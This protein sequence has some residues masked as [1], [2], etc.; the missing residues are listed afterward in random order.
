MAIS[1]TPIYNGDTPLDLRVHFLKVDRSPSNNNLKKTQRPIF[2]EDGEVNRDIVE[3]IEIEPQSILNLEFEESSLQLGIRGNIRVDNMFNILETIDLN[4]TTQFEIYV[5]IHAKDQELTDNKV[6]NGV[7]VLCYVT[8]LA[9][10]SGGYIN[11]N[12]MFEFEE[13]YVNNLRNI[14]LDR[15]VY[16]YA[17]SIITIID[18]LEFLNNQVYFAAY[19]PKVPFITHTKCSQPNTA[20]STINPGAVKDSKQSMYDVILLM[21]EDTLVGDQYDNNDHSANFKCPYLRMCNDVDG[22]RRMLFAPFVGDEHR[23]LLHVCNDAEQFQKHVDNQYNFSSVY[24]EKF[25]FGP[26]ASITSL[27]PNS[28]PKNAVETYNLSRANFQTL[29]ENVWGNYVIANVGNGSPDVG[30]FFANKKTFL[31]LLRQYAER[32]FSGVPIAYNIPILSPETLKTFE[33]KQGDVGGGIRGEMASRG[34]YN[35]MYNKVAKS[36]LTITETVT[37]ECEGMLYRYPNKFMWIEK[38]DNDTEGGSLQNKLFY[39]NRVKHIFEGS[40]YRTELQGS[41]WTGKTEG[42]QVY[43]LFDPFNLAA[44]RE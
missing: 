31:D 8:N 28:S 35:N 7:D 41:K 2:T 11:N 44:D 38:F 21:L 34:Q 6:N 13:A 5:H 25:A 10:A 40:E 3:V 37:F 33:V 43:D 39:V 12:V 15:F 26:L 4:N 30:K 36:F 29:K 24:T 19:N 14:S 18:A 23:R 20:F 27:D 42:G 32:E 16:D 1:E 9:N 22:E 17:D